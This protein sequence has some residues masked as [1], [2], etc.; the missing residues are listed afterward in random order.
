MDFNKSVRMINSKN[1]K[2][3]ICS[4]KWVLS[5]S[6]LRRWSS[7]LHWYGN[8]IMNLCKEQE[9]DASGIMVKENEDSDDDWAVVFNIFLILIS[10]FCLNST[11]DLDTH[12]KLAQCTGGAPQLASTPQLTQAW[13]LFCVCVCVCLVGDS[14]CRLS[15]HSLLAANNSWGERCGGWSG[16]A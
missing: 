2:T 1:I 8:V 4:M 3:D 12:H 9:D 15:L 6:T 13:P 14:Q 11:V 7:G 10:Y 5:A 16:M